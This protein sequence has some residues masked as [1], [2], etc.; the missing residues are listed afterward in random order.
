MVLFWTISYIL[1][2]LQSHRD[3]TFGMPVLA[4]L[5]NLA[6]EF[7]Y[8]LVFPAVKPQVYGLMVWLFIDLIMFYQLIKYGPAEFNIDKKYFMLFISILLAIVY[9]FE[10]YA[11]FF[12]LQFDLYYPGF[13]LALFSNLMMSILF[14]S[15]YTRR[16]DMR[17]QSMGIAVSKFIGTLVPTIEMYVFHHGIIFTDI[18]Y[19]VSILCNIIDLFYILLIYFKIDLH[20]YVKLNITSLQ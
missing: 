17:G 15:M 13:Y 6:W 1:I 8:S 9:V 18:I 19:L 5:A 12:F 10:Y 11:Y 7:I 3:K 20:R 4:L 2:I 16:G 14:I